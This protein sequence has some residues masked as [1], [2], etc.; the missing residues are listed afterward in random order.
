MYIYTSIY[1]QTPLN[2]LV[3]ADTKTELPLPEET[4]AIAFTITLLLIIL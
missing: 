3:N 1:T 2:K 4:V